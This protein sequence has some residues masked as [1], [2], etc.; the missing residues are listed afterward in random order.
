MATLA[1]LR[2]RVERADRPA[3]SE[4]NGDPRLPKGL[5]GASQSLNRDV[6]PQRLC[7]C[8]VQ[9]RH[10]LRDVSEEDT[11]RKAAAEERMAQVWQRARV[12]GE[13]WR[14]T[15]SMQAEELAKKRKQ[16]LIEQVRLYHPCRPVHRYLR[17]SMFVSQPATGSCYCNLRTVKHY[18]L[19]GAVGSKPV[20]VGG[21]HCSQMERCIRRCEAH[22]TAPLLCRR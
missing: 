21:L 19:R 20:G 6:Y 9:A 4:G 10:I 12:P 16:E 2:E 7:A 1:E 22:H 17:G 11:R 3:E 8:P 15:S 18:R 5:R 14:T 13:L